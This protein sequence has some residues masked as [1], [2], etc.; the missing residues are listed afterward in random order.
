MKKLVFTLFICICALNLYCQN[1]I[2]IAYVFNRQS[3]IDSF[4]FNFPGCTVIDGN[5]GVSNLIDIND[6][7]TNFDSLKY[8]DTIKG[9]IQVLASTF[10][11]ISG[12]SGLKS[13]NGSFIVKGT[14]LAN[15]EGLDSLQEIK[16]IL[17]VEFNNQLI[18][19]GGFN[20]LN[21]IGGLEIKYQNQLLDVNEF[22]NLIKISGDLKIDGTSIENLDGFE[23]VDSIYGDLYIS[24]NSNLDTLNSFDSLTYIGKNLN[25]RLFNGIAYVEDFSRLT[26]IKNSLI[27][28]GNIEFNSSF[29]AL[30]KVD[31]IRISSNPIINEV[32]TFNEVDSVFS[33]IV[34]EYNNQ[35]ISISGFQNLNFLPY[36]SLN[37]NTFLS[38]ING[39][40]H[41]F[42][43]LSVQFYNNPFLSQCSII[44]ICLNFEIGSTGF[45]TFNQNGGGVISK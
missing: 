39:F 7:I 15:F 35:I 31:Y 4:P 21:K 26:L 40:N 28:E 13:I 1:C 17:K 8:V 25:I 16:G 42:R 36:L 11:D 32:T 43:L 37:S 29:N 20:N 3:Q 10:N 23:N 19:L 41:S 34:F 24:A 33:S 12:L 22:S 27:I 18:N 45:G 2:P 5:I 30:R 14:A 38:S 9:S 44:P 6:P